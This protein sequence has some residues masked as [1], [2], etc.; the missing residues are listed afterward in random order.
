MTEHPN[1]KVRSIDFLTPEQLQRKREVDRKS[2]RQ[3]RERN[4]AYISELEQKV[5]EFETRIQGLEHEFSAFVARCQCKGGTKVEHVTPPEDPQ[6]ETTVQEI[7][8]ASEADTQSVVSGK[9]GWVDKGWGVDQAQ[10]NSFANGLGMFCSTTC[11]VRIL[12][13]V[14][15]R[16]LLMAAHI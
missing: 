9:E 6:W 7:L 11:C 2:Q 4:R 13:N 12:L 15:F 16:S 1:G 5:R 10:W 3:A 8:A 14:L